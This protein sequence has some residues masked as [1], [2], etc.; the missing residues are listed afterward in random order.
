MTSRWYILTLPAIKYV[1]APSACAQSVTYMRGQLELSESGLLHWQFVLH[2]SSA[3][4]SSAVRRMFPSAHVEAT[5]S[6]AACSYVWKEETYV[7]GSRFEVGEAPVHRN[8]KTDWDLVWTQ[9]KAGDIVS[10]PADIRIRCYSTLRRIQK[11]FMV[12]S[13][14]QRTVNVYW[15]V[16]GSGKSHRAWSEAGLDA[17]PKDPNTKFWDG[18]NGH[19]HVV[20]DEFRGSIGISHIL[21][22]FDRYPVV[23]EVKGGAVC[24]TSRTLWITSNLPPE[25]WYPDLDA[26]TTQALLRRLTIRHFD[27]A[28]VPGVSDIEDGSS[29]IES[30]N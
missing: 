12:P 23:V 10:I 5:R 14:C 11:D 24:F 15:G 18:Y 21:R 30:T 20:I 6:S 8:R 13:A 28:F 22:W 7:D 25:S 17:F 27:T 3:Q 2:L 26:E 29:G 1:F 4:R 16:T 9:A 19:P